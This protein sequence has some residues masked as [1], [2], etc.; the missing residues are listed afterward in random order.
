MQHLDEGTIHTWLDG[1][2]PR[3]EA[4]AVE[5]HV[6][7]CRQCADA[8][9]EARGLIAASSRIL[10]ALDDVP[11]EVAPSLP[12]GAARQPVGA[13][14]EPS[15]ISHQPSAGGAP[16]SA[17]APVIAQPPTHSAAKR[18]QRRWFRG[19]SLAA[20]AT[21]VVAVGTF[22]LMRSGADKPSS[23]EVAADAAAGRA[24]VPFVAG[25]SASPALSA[26]I[27]TPAPA[28]ARVANE[29]RDAVATERQGFADGARPAESR[30][31]SEPAV[32]GSQREQLAKQ[33][34]PKT[35]ATTGR[36]VT[37]QR[38]RDE[39]QARERPVSPAPQPAVVS[40]PP[41]ARPDTTRVQV[42]RGSKS[43]A[44]T[45]AARQ[46][47]A[48]VAEDMAAV[49]GSIRGRVT[50]ANHTGIEGAMVTVENTAIGVASSRTGEFE[51]NGVPVGAQ[52]IVARRA[53]Y[54]AV[55][56]PVTVTASQVVSADIRLA[57][58]SN[59]LAETATTRGT[60]ALGAAMARSPSP[61]VTAHGCY[62]LG[63][64]PGSP[65][66]RADF[67]QVPRRI[68]LDSAVVPARSD[69]I[70]Y[71]VRDLTRSGV[72]NGV[73]RPTPPDGIEVQWT[74]GTKTATMRLTG[75]SGPVLRGS[76]EEID[77][78]SATG[79]AAA[80]VAGKTRCDPR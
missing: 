80:V 51:L 38:E 28:N 34:L 21:I 31:L 7:E 48:K 13:S 78:V 46:S 18:A 30:R 74:Y 55:S 62:E 39:E 64:T 27:A 72:V 79:D 35:V 45:D 70:W 67:R 56:Q 52:Q 11:R 54:A 4:E 71:Q 32:V 33:E 42:F 1:Q 15:A 20:A 43:E 22:A 9:A 75:L 14:P 24:S 49:T 10:T 60:A 76:V 53:G 16:A 61:P 44:R 65:Q 26:P 36:A 29:A 40:A 25:D 59:A 2:L 19:P 47:A 12:V 58:A 69:G 68:A 66:A 37:S 5:A 57:P 23:Q 77:R 6:A 3:D 41:P 8:V 17:D 73:W 63:I 50:D